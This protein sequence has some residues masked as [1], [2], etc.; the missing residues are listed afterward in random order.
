MILEDSNPHTVPHKHMLLQSGNSRKIQYL[1]LNLPIGLL[2]LDQWHKT[3][4]VTNSTTRIIQEPI[5]AMTI[6]KTLP[7][8]DKH[9][10]VLWDYV[11]KYWHLREIIVL[12]F[13]L[14]RLSFRLWVWHRE[15]HML[16]SLPYL[17]IVIYAVLFH[18]QKLKSFLVV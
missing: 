10:R 1:V 2:F 3:C 9:V 14:L 13:M 6:V 12:H 18:N 16:D 4:K 15:R 17:F 5:S 11:K 7:G 8:W